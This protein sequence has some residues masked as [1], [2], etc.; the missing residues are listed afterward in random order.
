MELAKDAGQDDVQQQLQARQCH[1]RMLSL[2]CYSNGPLDPLDPAAMLRLIVLAQHAACFVDD[3][4]AHGQQATLLARCKGL[5]AGR[6][7]SWFC[8]RSAQS[9][10]CRCSK[11]LCAS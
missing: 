3:P 11:A 7:G 6:S 9:V 4:V 2:L 5:M 10:G 1:L 8:W